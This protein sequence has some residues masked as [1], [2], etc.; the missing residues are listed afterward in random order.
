MKKINVGLFDLGVKRGDNSGKFGCFIVFGD[1]DSVKMTVEEIIERVKGSVQTGGVVMFMGN[2]EEVLGNNEVANQIVSGLCD[3]DLH[4]QINGTKKMP[5]IFDNVLF[6]PDSV[7][8][9]DEVDF[10]SEVRIYADAKHGDGEKIDVRGIVEAVRKKFPEVTIY[11]ANRYD[12]NNNAKGS[13]VIRSSLFRLLQ[14]QMI[15]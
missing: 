10:L 13:S 11:I 12:E 3:Y 15:R 7:E 6:C 9:I 5:H 8:Q 4:M 2:V 14:C 1:C